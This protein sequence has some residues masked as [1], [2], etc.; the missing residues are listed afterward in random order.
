MLAQG[1][2]AL[3]SQLGIRLF[4]GNWQTVY[5]GGARERPIHDRDRRGQAL[6]RLPA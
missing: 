4:L 2:K 1:A 5:K 6:V 3:P